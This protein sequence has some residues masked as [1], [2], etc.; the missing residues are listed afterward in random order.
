MRKLASTAALAA[1]LLAGAEVRAADEPAMFG[2]RHEM[3]LSAE[4]LFG[5]T[6]TSFPHHSSDDV[7]LLGSSPTSIIP[8]TSTIAKPR[9]AFDAFVVGRLSV[10]GAA[11]YFRVS[12]TNSML[13]TTTT[14]TSSGFLLAARI[15]YAAPVARRAAVWPR[16]GLT[17]VHHA[18]ESPFVFPTGPL[19]STTTVYALTIE[20]PVVVIVAPHFFV[21]LGPTYAHGIG[22]HSSPYDT[23][24][25]KQIDFGVQ[26]GLGGF[27]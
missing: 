19:N 18:N 5:Y 25:P 7:S 10:G 17:F 12:S 16:L 20:V 24:Y 13:P 15:G 2:D 27:F 3:V 26:A 23:L 14:T 8:S 1:A 22:G 6:H 4:N 11:G 9:V 21:E